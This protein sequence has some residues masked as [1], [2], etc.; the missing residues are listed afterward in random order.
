MRAPSTNV[1]GSPPSVRK[2]AQMHTAARHSLPPCELL[3]APGA[4]R[5]SHGVQHK[6]LMTPSGCHMMCTV[7]SHMMPMGAE[8]VSYNWASVFT[9]HPFLAPSAHYE[10]Q[11]VAQASMAR[12]VI[13]DRRAHTHTHARSSRAAATQALYWTCK[14]ESAYTTEHMNR[15]Y[16]STNVPSSA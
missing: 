9:T 6:V 2:Q 11:D 13:N 10:G 8:R 15:L 4:K 7:L 16:I 1:K 14:N 3:M 12:G 5:L